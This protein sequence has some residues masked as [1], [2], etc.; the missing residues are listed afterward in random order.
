MQSGSSDKGHGTEWRT[1]RFDFNTSRRSREDTFGRAEWGSKDSIT[2]NRFTR[3]NADRNEWHSE[4]FSREFSRRS[5]EQANE[6]ARWQ[7]E[8]SNENSTL[9]PDNSAGTAPKKSIFLEPANLSDESNKWMKRGLVNSLEINT[10]ETS[11]SGVIPLGAPRLSQLLQEPRQ[12]AGLAERL[13]KIYREFPQPANPRLL[14]VA[15]VGA[16]NAGKSTLM[17]S[18]IGEEVSVVSHKAHTTRERVL[19]VLTDDN[20]Q[21]VFLDTPGV[22]PDNRRA[23]MDRTLV[24]SSWRSLDEADHVILM[25]DGAWL[26]KSE[27]HKADEL[28]LSRL[29]NLALPTTLVIN[30]MD[31]I[32]EEE[33]ADDLKKMVDV[34]QKQCPSI[35]NVIYI[36]ALQGEGLEAVKSDL[37]M[38]AKPA[39][40]MYPKEI[41]NDMPDL[42]RAEELIRVEFFKR[43]HQYIPYMLRQENVGWTELPNGTLRIDQNIYVERE[44]Q[45]KIVVGANGSVIDRVVEDARTQIAAAL[46]RPVQLFIQVKARKR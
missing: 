25:V 14:R 18:I 20:H 31:L 45:L 42:K 7:A 15:V 11:V 39:K 36:S 40:W 6:R 4:R 26:L 38:R 9:N 23:K 34:Y 44:S 1:E 8:R 28:I 43:L 2:R 21:L 41:K 27:K 16:A 32:D 30:K 13:A 3:P 12:P 46:K 29:K 35:A 5:N 33:S 22:V 37:F 19:G 10:A 17:N 24:T